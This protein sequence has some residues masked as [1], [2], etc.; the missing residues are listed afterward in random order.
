MKLKTLKFKTIRQAVATLAVGA[1]IAVPAAAFAQAA[2][3]APAAPAATTAPAP[4]A[5]TPEARAAIKELLDVMNTKENLT[6]TF[7]AMS[8]TLP[9]QMAQAMNQQIENN[10]ALTPEQKTKVRSGMAEPFNAALKEAQ[11]IVANPKLVD[12]TIDKMYGIY[13]KYYTVAEVKQLVAFYKSPLGNKTL[14]AM[15]QAIN[16]SLQA[17]VANFQPRIAAVMDKTLKTQIDAATKK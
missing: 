8:Q 5:V 12:D 11:G 16:E 17:G 9:P 13:A 7:A 10:A 2:K 3:N 15:P 14:T 4:V 1:S 6:K